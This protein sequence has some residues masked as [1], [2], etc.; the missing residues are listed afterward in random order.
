MQELV[1]TVDAK[2]VDLAFARVIKRYGRHVRMPGFRPGHLP[3]SV[4]MSNYGNEIRSYVF[5]DLYEHCVKDARADSIPNAVGDTLIDN[6]SDEMLPERGKPFV[7]K[8]RVEKDVEFELKPI[9]EG[10]PL[11][12]LNGVVTD[13][14]VDEMLE[15]LRYQKRTYQTV[16]GLEAGE[17]MSLV[18]RFSDSE[19]LMKDIINPNVELSVMFGQTPFEPQFSDHVRGLKAGESGEFDF[20][21][22]EK[23]SFEKIRGKLLHIK[24]DVVSV[25]RPE[26]PEIDAAF[27]RSYGVKDGKLETLRAQLRQNMVLQQERQLQTYNFTRLL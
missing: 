15:K 9:A 18:C 8:A 20:T 19:G 6:G 23:A 7:F 1:V 3:D 5:D 13:N 26:L 24:V 17:D 2:E 16:D 4:L 27:V 25:A 10:T 11:E 22:S 12:R 14:D 21:M